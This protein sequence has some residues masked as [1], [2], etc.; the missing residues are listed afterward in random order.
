MIINTETEE[1]KSKQ[2]GLRGRVY[3]VGPSVGSLQTLIPV[4]ATSQHKQH[5][6][7]SLTRQLSFLW[8]FYKRTP[9]GGAGT[10]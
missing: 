6:A 5:K 9:T 1:P 7:L 10:P 8:W 3:S 4:S 2:L